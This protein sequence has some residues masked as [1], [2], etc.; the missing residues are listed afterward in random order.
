MVSAAV[1]VESPDQTLAVPAWNLPTRIAFRFCFVYFSLYCLSTQIITSFFSL[2][3]VGWLSDPSLLPPWREIIAFT[4]AH[5]LRIKSPL[6]FVE[7]GSGDRMIDWVLVFFLLTVSA[8][9]TLV[10]S[11]LDRRRTSYT[12]LHKWFL[13]FLR[14]A[15]AGQMLSYGFIKAVPMQMPSPQLVT[16]TE[17]FGDFSPMGVLWTAVGASQPYEIASGCLELIAGVLLL[18]PRTTVLGALLALADMSYVFLLNMTYD[19]PVKLLSFHLI[20][21]SL[22]L[23][24]PQFR[25][26]A[27]FFLLDRAVDPAPKHPL[28][29]TRRANRIALAVQA[30]FAL[31]LI[32]FNAWQTPVDWRK[33]GDG[34][35][36]PALYGIW[37]VDQCSVDGQ[38]RPPLLSDNDRW[39][40]VIFDRYD[41]AAIDRMS[42]TRVFY[43]AALDEKKNTLALTQHRGNQKLSF[44]SSRPAPDRLLLDGVL[45]GHKTHIELRLETGHTFLVK[46]RGFHWI[47]EAPFN[48]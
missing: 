42:D 22:V 28:F 26:L 44:A 19:V 17:R 34:A 15:L 23:L 18:V 21:I 13:L 4:A 40:R 32:G 35:P 39:R 27:A 10:W 48:R 38:P 14:F 8:A 37:N 11:L 36:K 46:T 47:S 24:A 9:V 3:D 25:R 30:A 43:T 33:Y 1:P 6:A 12:A 20:F 16:L 5:I 45:D 2:Q 29:S 31:W 7:T 41:L